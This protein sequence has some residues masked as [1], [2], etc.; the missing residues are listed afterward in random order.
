M[1][2]ICLEGALLIKCGECVKGTQALRAALAT[3]AESGWTGWFTEFL[4]ILAEGFIAIERY[5]EASAAVDE[6]LER[7]AKGGEHWYLPEL[8]RLKGRLTLHQNGNADER[9]AEDFYRRSLQTSMK[10]GAGFWLLKSA[11]DLAELKKRQ[12]QEAE[13]RA[14]LGPVYQNFTEGFG[15]PDLKTARALL[16]ALH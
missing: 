10:Q 14:V 12:K 1:S 7:S 4:A 9:R 11:L 6:A 5:D 13:A 15:T 16:S 2:V 8:Y 3:C